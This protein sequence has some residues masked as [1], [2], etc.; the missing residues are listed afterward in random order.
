MGGGKTAGMGHD[1]AHERALFILSFRQ[2][3]ELTAILSRAGWRIVAARRAD[4]IRQRVAASGTAIAIVDARGAIDDGIAATAELAQVAGHGDA[5]LV[6][7]AKGDVDRLGALY[8]AGA[9]HF[10]ISPVTEEML[11]QGVRF[12]ERH[13]HRMGGGWHDPLAGGGAPLGWRLDSVRGSVQLTPALAEATGFGETATPRGLLRQLGQDG[14]RTALAAIR[15]LG[16]ASPATAFAHDLPGLGR[17]VQHV[18]RDPHSQRLHALVEP[19][20]RV[21]D[22]GAVVREALG[23][24]RDLAGTLRWIDRRI[25]A[26]E[27]PGIR[28]IA[29]GGIDPVNR[30]QGRSVGDT[31]LRAVERRIE[32]AVRDAGLVRA[33]VARLGGTEFAVLLPHGADQDLEAALARAVARPFVAGDDMVALTLRQACDTVQPGEDGAALVRRVQALLPGARAGDGDRPVAVLDAQRLAADIA[34]A[35]ETREI[36]ILF[37][38]QVKLTSGRIIGVEALARWRHGREGELGPELLFDAAARAGLA[39]R[40]SAHVQREAMRIAAGWPGALG[41]LRLSINVTAED[42]AQAD[43][44]DTLL[45]RADASGFPRERLTV[46]VTESGLIAELGEA[47]GLLA[48]LRAAGCRV[49]ID[50]FGTGYSSLAYL[51][52]LPLDYLKI[53]KKLAQDIVG[54]PRDRVVVRGVI[55]MA[56]SLGLTV[57]AEGV[58]TEA[59]RDAL[60]AEGCQLYQGFLCAEPLEVSALVALVG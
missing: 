1:A 42:V 49:A 52:A 33:A 46:E 22:I 40:L 17:V 53:D 59:Q 29:I 35:I 19:L 21:G 36:A 3:D 30:R 20:A 32:R 37:Q 44:A 24:V 34:R 45:A 5:V 48:A 4:G 47:A 55:D 41:H 6:L 51:K 12:A 31:L 14:R 8:E 13:V 39:G 15:R 2:R 10:L 7:V 11:V 38:P 16:T 26:G 50:D 54:S 58:E 25:E 43:F 18:A 60:A 9:T 28:V 27:V 56:R 57:V 23:S